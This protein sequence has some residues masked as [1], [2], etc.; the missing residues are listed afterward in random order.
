MA[1]NEES[2]LAELWFVDRRIR[3]IQRAVLRKTLADLL[4]EMGI[5]PDDTELKVVHT[6]VSVP[7]AIGKSLV[8][9]QQFGDLVAGKL[10]RIIGRHIPPD[11]VSFSS[12][13][14][15]LLITVRL[16]YRS[17]YGYGTRPGIDLYPE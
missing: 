4:G 7:V 10:G 3:G 13:D 17:N 16:P 14:D 1:S 2:P 5:H 8:E 15:Q 11:N 9:V 6:T 12:L